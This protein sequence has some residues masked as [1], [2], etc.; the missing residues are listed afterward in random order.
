MIR[1]TD[2]LDGITAEM[3]HGFFVGWPD[4]PSPEKHLEILAGS[5]EVVLAIDDETGRVVGFVNALT[6]GVLSAFIPLLEVL[7]GYQ[8]QGIGREL[9]RRMMGKLSGFYAV[10]VV[11]DADVMPFYE[12]F[13]MRPG[14]AM[15]LR[16]RTDNRQGDGDD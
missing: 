3:L 12:R 2:S 1:Y 16:R 7:P 11:C 6:D 13:G 14:N 9:V 5:D 4:P 15:M 8:G 10:D